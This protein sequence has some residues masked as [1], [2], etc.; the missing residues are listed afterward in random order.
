MK[1]IKFTKEELTK[2]HATGSDVQRIYK[3]ENGYG[4]SVV[5]FSIPGSILG[6]YGSYTD[7]E[8]EW[9][10]AVIKFNSDNIKD[11]ELTY[12]T[13]ITDD[14]IGHLTESEVQETLKQIELL[15]K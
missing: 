8:D 10:L 15:T 12:Q 13:P 1:K 11:F 6:G 7:N 14:V 4:A 2:E 9:E 5:R 3:F